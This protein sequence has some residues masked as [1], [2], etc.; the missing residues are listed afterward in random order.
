MDIDLDVEHFLD[1]VMENFPELT[2]K[3]IE[4]NYEQVD[5]ISRE[6]A[7]KYLHKARKNLSDREKAPLPAL[8]AGYDERRKE[9]FKRE[10]RKLGIKRASEK[11]D[12]RPTWT[13]VKA[14]D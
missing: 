7:G 6:L 14:T 4:E 12:D 11:S 10:G 5:E 8:S 13:K 9:R 3:Y 2:E 1:Y